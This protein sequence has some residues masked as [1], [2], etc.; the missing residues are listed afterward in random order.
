MMHSEFRFTRQGMRTPYDVTVRLEAVRSDAF[1]AHLGLGVPSE[2]SG[3][4]AV[5]AGVLSAY[6]TVAADMPLAVTVVEIVDHSGA[7]GDLGYKICGEAAM[8]RLLGVPDKAPSP[9]YPLGAA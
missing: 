7:T 8:Y 5:I 9:G 6:Q 3:H 4:A 2:I 1:S